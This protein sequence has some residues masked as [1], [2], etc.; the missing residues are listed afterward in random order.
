VGWRYGV[1]AD[2]SVTFIALRQKLNDEDLPRE[3]FNVNV[4]HKDEKD[5]EKSYNK[6]IESI[7]KAE[8]FN[9]IDQGNKTI[10]ER[11]YKYLVETHK[12]KLSK[13]DMSNYVLFANKDGVILILT[14][15]T[16]AA[17]F[18]KFKALFNSIATS[19]TF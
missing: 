2:K 6:F 7:G 13:E 3:N 1:P 12:N 5:L 8:G 17:N 9:I 11:K 14:M 10:K 16:T 18:E 4:L 15:V 19:L